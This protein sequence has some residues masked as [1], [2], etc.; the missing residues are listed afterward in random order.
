MSD[1]DK[2]RDFLK[3][4]S[5]RFKTHK[6]DI[7]NQISRALAFEHFERLERPPEAAPATLELLNF[8]PKSRINYVLRAAWIRTQS[9]QI[10]LTNTIRLDH[11][12]D[13]Q[14]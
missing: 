6:S 5:L 14:N 4:A 9:L 7:A 2:L 11:F 12:R 10:N 1:N 3:A 13:V 8:L